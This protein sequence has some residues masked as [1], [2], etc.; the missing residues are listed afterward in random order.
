MHFPEQYINAQTAEI[1]YQTRS[2]IDDSQHGTRLAAQVGDPHIWT[3]SIDTPPL[4]YSAVMG[5]FASTVKLQGRALSCRFKNPLRSVGLGLGANCRIR[6]DVIASSNII[7]VTGAPASKMGV[8]LP[9]D[10]ISFAG[11]QKVYMVQNTVNTSGLGQATIEVSPF[12]RSA[13]S[14][15]TAIQSGSDVYFNLSLKTDVQK[16]NLDAR[17]GE[18]II[19]LQFEER[20]NA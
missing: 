18:H 11:H 8:L 3:L 12:T 17:K 1:G 2:Q 10:F 16:L 6:A 14:A 4:G 5:L 15:G 9:G 13:L 7:K 19:N 20:L